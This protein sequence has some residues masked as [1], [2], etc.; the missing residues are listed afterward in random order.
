MDEVEAVAS[1]LSPHFDAVRD[2]FA[3]F[4]P[5]PGKPLRRLARVKCV[6]DEAAGTDERHF[7]MT[8]ET[9]LVV[10]LAPQIVYLDL[11]PMVAVLAHELG[12]AADFLYP[13]CFTWPRHGAEGVVWVGD[14][15]TAKAA[16]WRW[17]FGKR[18]ARSRTPTDDG[19]PAANW[20]RAWQE[21]EPDQIE[22]AADGIAELVTGRRPRYCG[23]CLVQCYDGG[24][25][26]PAGLR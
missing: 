10:V 6:I 14:T 26:R 7:A 4:C 16:A 8:S 23:P 12:H 22:W 25:E 21:R 11:G 9:G 15:S 2:E 17:R 1:A 18:T 5:T 19:P 20:T 13:G 24:I 3:S